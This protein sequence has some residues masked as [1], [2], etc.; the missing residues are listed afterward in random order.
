MRLIVSVH[1]ESGWKNPKMA[2]ILR[3]KSPDFNVE[4]NFSGDRASFH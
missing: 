1:Q 4:N 2:L 3:F